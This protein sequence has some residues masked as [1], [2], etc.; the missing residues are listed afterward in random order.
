MPEV[1]PASPVPPSSTKTQCNNVNEPFQPK[2]T[3]VTVT[4]NAEQTLERTLQS[5]ASQTYPHIEHL[6]VDGLSNDGTLSLIQEYA[7][8]NSVCDNPHDIQFIREPDNGL[9]DAMNKGIDNAN[10]DYLV[11]LNAGDKFHADNTLAEIATG[12]SSVHGNELDE[13]T[14]PAV[15]YGETDIV[16]DNGEF[17]RHRRLQAPE[18]LTWRSFL[19]GML[20]CHQSFYV[21]ADIARQFHYNLRYRF[22][23]DFDWCVRIMKDAVQKGLPLYN[24]RQILTDYLAEGMTTKN[25]RKSLFERLRIMCRHYGCMAAIRQH[26]WFVVRAMVKR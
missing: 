15:L 24:T 14:W 5:V 8:D 16:D 18:V 22:S 2:F 26:L 11:F 4:Y 19:N 10:G 20:V 9:Y 12:L 23:G 13:E 1:D 7:E 25:H 21:R 6:I 3:V 17:L